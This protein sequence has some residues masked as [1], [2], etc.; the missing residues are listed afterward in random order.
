VLQLRFLFC[1]H[2]WLAAKGIPE[3]WMT[4]MK[5]NEIVGMQ[6]IKYET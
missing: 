4:A 1:P 5:T 2:N 6:V 3:F